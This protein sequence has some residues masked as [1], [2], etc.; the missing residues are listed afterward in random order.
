MVAGL[1]IGSAI[2]ALAVQDIVKSFI[3]GASILAE[4]PFVIGDFILVKEGSEEN[5]D[6]RRYYFKKY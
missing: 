4:K 2:M 1:G 6:S 5:G 3:S